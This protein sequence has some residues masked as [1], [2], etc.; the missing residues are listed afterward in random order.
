MCNA[1]CELNAVSCQSRSVNT[2]SDV[3]LAVLRSNIC[4]HGIAIV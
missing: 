3:V 1:S 4:H 2:F